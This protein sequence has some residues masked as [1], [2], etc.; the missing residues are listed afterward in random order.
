[1]NRIACFAFVSVLLASRLLAGQPVADTK[2]VW[3][4]EDT[5][6]RYVKSNDL[7]HYLTLWHSDFLG[8]PTTSP[9]PVRKEHITDW[10][11]AHT[12]KGETLKS[13]DLERLEAQQT[14]DDVTVTY[15]I[16]T[17]W[18]GKDAV[19]K[20]SIS[21]IIHTWRHNSD[22]T[23]KIISGMGAYADAQGH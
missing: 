21:R 18:V 7:E 2:E 5:Y 15:R 12:S 19:D 11:T 13:Y 1:M 20:P 4:M 14:G 17:I 3:S 16:H 22:R 6:W 9:V 8:W 23:W 10:I